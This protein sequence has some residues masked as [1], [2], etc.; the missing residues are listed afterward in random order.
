[1]K[2][3]ILL[4]FIIGISFNFAQAKT[5]VYV[6]NFT[7]YT[8]YVQKTKQTGTPLSNKKWK[9]LT[10]IIKPFS[11]AKILE[12]A[13]DIGIKKNQNYIFETRIKTN[14]PALKNK[15]IKLFQKIKGKTI[16]SKMWWSFSTGRPSPRWTDKRTLWNSPLCLKRNYQD[17]ENGP[18]DIVLR[19]KAV[20]SGM[21]NN[22][23]YVIGGKPRHK[24]YKVE[25][26]R[27][28]DKLNI[29]AL[30]VYL[31][32]IKVA[33]ITIEKKPGI[34]KRASLIAQYIQGYDVI[35]FSEIF[36][37]ELR[38][39][40]LY[41]LKKY[42]YKYSTCILGSG[43]LSKRNK[44]KGRLGEV[45]NQPFIVKFDHPSF[46]KIP[47]YTQGGHGENLFTKGV[48]KPSS[49][50]IIIVSKYPITQAKEFIYKSS[51]WSEDRLEKKGAVYAKVN[52]MGKYYHIFGTHPEAVLE[53]IKLDQLRELK[54]FADLLHIPKSEPILFGGD[55]NIDTKDI[56]K[57]LSILNAKNPN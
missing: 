41:N 3:N 52:K 11:K 28:P 32:E 6:K 13:R 16:G 50:G 29:L 18:H 31:M 22:V 56:Q 21:F 1:M 40:L 45:L 47:L 26:A 44:N 14:S 35:I 8:F 23:E 42:G 17:S 12:F 43:F 27:S 49:G 10:R 38:G 4:F 53:H 19:A 54:R 33:G 34:A 55:M 57:M 2:I 15:V 24:E 5:K 25:P 46:G 20:E 9:Q 7:P 37:N 30:N 51:G 36:V 39:Q 48:L